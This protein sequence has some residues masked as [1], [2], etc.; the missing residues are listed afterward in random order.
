[1]LT[2]PAAE[3]ELEGTIVDFSD[4]G[5]RARVFAVIDVIRKQIVVVPVEK[6]I[7]KGDDSCQ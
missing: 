4:S 5:Q 3:D 7:R 6:L 1:V 2:A